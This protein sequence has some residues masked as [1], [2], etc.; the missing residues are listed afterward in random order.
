MLKARPRPSAHQVVGTAETAAQAVMEAVGVEDVADL[1]TDFSCTVP[2]SPCFKLTRQ[3]ASPLSA[4]D[5][6]A[7]AALVALHWATQA[8]LE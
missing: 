3:R 6:E 5:R 4:L 7:R 2:P 1:P 8:S